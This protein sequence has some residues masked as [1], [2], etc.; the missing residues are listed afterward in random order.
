[1]KVWL[2][3][4]IVLTAACSVDVSEH[5]NDRTDVD[6]KTPVG[7]MAVR[8][9]VEA[10][11][12]GLPVYPGATPLRD[13]DDPGS[14]DVNIGAFGIGLKVS[15]AKFE[16]ADNEQRVLSFYREALAADGAVTECRGEI[17]YR[18]GRPVCTSKRL[19]RG[20]QLVTGPEHD[21]RIVVV[22]PRQG[23]SE[24]ALV[25]VQ[26]SGTRAP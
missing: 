3:A 22:T 14:A 7:S 17:D 25:H 16:T 19:E 18:G 11:D 23:R 1:M 24:I 12:T 4:G 20:V 6:I 15:A 13:D 21:Q 26:T 5:G 8:A 10:P 9:N 2:L